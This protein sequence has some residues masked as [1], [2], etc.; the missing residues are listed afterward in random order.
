MRKSRRGTLARKLRLIILGSI[1]TAVAT[2]TASFLISSSITARA[3]LKSRLITM[4]DVIGQ[5]STAA[6]NFRDESAAEE[7]LTALTADDAIV[8]A[9]LYDASGQLFAQYQRRPRLLA[10]SG[11]AEQT[12][13]TVSSYQ[14]AQR[15]V[16]MKGEHV[17]DIVLISDMEDLHREQRRLLTLSAVLLILTLALGGMI[18]SILQRQVSDPISHLVAA[19]GAVTSSQRYDTR[20]NVDSTEEIN[21]LG[22][23][24]NAMLAE[25]QR[26]DGDLQLNRTNLENELA[27]RKRINLELAK[28]KDEAD[29]AN[30]AKSEFL[31]NMSHEIR[32]PMNGV[33]G[34]TELALETNLNPEQR[35]YMSMV[36]MSAESLLSIINDILDFSKIEAGRLE[37]ENVE[38]NLCDLVSDTL[39]GFALPAHSK[40]LELLYELRPPSLVHVIG[41]PNR[42]RQVLLNVIANAIKF[43]ERG[44]V[45]VTV[46]RDE[47]VKDFVQ[48]TIRDTGIGIPPEKQKLI[49]EAFS[50]ADSSQTRNYGGTGLGLTISARLVGLMGGEITV[51][52]V[53]HQGSEFR[54]AIPLPTG[55][56]AEQIESSRLPGVHALVVDDNLTNRQIVG[57]MLTQIGMEVETA[58]SAAQALSVLESAE[59]TGDVTKVVIVDGDMPGMDGFEL[60]ERIRKKRKFAGVILMMLACGRHQSEQIA[61]CREIGVQ[62]YLIKPIRRLELIDMIMMLSVKTGEADGQ[63]N[64]DRVQMNGLKRRL[65]LLAAEDNRVNQRLLVRLLEKEGHI[66]KVVEDGEAAVAISAEEQFNAILMDVQ[67]PKMDGLEATRQIRLR[68]KKTGEHIPIIALTAHAMKGDRDRC[69]QAGMDVY[70]AK[71]LHKDELLKT[72]EQFS[73]SGDYASLS[74]MIVPS[75]VMN[76]DDA[77][78]CTGGNSALLKELCEVF[79]EESPILLEQLSRSIEGGEPAEVH[80]IAHRLKTTVGTLG[81]T[82]AYKA[83]LSIEQ[84]TNDSGMEGVEGLRA[85]LCREVEALRDA[86]REF[87]CSVPA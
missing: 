73:R 12:L 29:A 44:E 79:L 5:N 75:R 15:P 36:K 14:S 76:V 13:S 84:T 7:V 56:S 78:R 28:A 10:C 37:L 18:G 65:K 21:T 68:E 8:S 59:A 62:G 60:A 77:L 11:R 24:F 46:D 55:Q 57:G 22:N 52:S 16:M 87:V 41:D 80:Q 33:I 34:M 85:E 9:C 39:K 58:E 71:P 26:R 61:R 67:M 69:L 45:A 1:A 54:I 82:R 30:R 31:A 81:G 6:L 43:T 38:F 40:G 25:I 20:V 70:I 48:F 72:L 51:Q 3:E 49:F 86:V 2:L 17:G 19:M 53:P 23:G 32:T 63:V 50:Q 83:A 64:E 27:A 66:V 74:P 42:L 35:E 47:V 4:T